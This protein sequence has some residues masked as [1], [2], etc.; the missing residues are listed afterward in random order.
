MLGLLVCGKP[1]ELGG[2][3]PDAYVQFVRF[4]GTELTDPIRSQ[5]EIHGPLPELLRH[6]D[7]LLESN[8]SIASDIASGPLERRSADYPLSALQ[9][10]TRNA[11]LHRSYESMHSPVRVYWYSDRIEIHSP[12]GPFGSVTRKNFGEGGATS[13]RNPHLA[14]ALKN[15]GYVQRFGM[16][17]PLARKHMHENGNPEPEFT[18]EDTSVLVTLRG[19][20]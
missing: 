13:Y 20:K 5:R 19:R 15:L 11:V 17:I 10:L 14:E 2:V 9:Q 3:L 8:L 6:L 12:G 7:E 18:V 16:G 1:F 4:D